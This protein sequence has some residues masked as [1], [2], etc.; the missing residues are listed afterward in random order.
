MIFRFNRRLVLAWLLAV[1]L[2]FGLLMVKPR[3]FPAPS[4]PAMAPSG[5]PGNIGTA[6]PP[7]AATGGATGPAAKGLWGYLM[8]VFGGAGGIDPERLLDEVLPGSFYH[9]PAPAPGSGSWWQAFLGL[10][11]GAPDLA[12][13][14][15]IFSILPASA[16]PAWEKAVASS[17]VVPVS[18]SGATPGPAS[19]PGGTAEDA[20][21]L[22]PAGSAQ[23]TPIASDTDDEEPPPVAEP[24]PAPATVGKVKTWGKDPAVIIYHTHA[25]ESFLPTLQ[26]VMAA[27]VRP[28]RAEQA[29]STDPRYTVMRVG[30]ELASQLY[31]KHGISVVQSREFPDAGGRGASYS[32]SAPIVRGLLAKY[33]SAKVVIDLHRD[34]APRSSTTATVKGKRVARIMFVV[35]SDHVFPHPHWRENYAL[36]VKLNQ[37]IEDKFPGLSRGIMVKDYQ[38]NQQLSTDMLLIEVGGAENT[39]AEELATADLLAEAITRLLRGP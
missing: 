19:P 30:E 37:I 8:R 36:A 26:S 29:F 34:A 38:Y 18:S 1:V 15:M 5:G 13:T 24:A 28:H 11:A 33:P 9:P 14:D 31:G 20:A 27:D 6:K 10:A 21:V 22:P 4:V 39:L 17:A 3:S 35:G 32:R 25:T 2:T 12:P 7:P 23:I 16:R